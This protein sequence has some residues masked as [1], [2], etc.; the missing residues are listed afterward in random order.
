MRLLT[1]SPLLDQI[2]DALLLGKIVVV[3]L[4]EHLLPQLLGVVPVSYDISVVGILYLD[5]P[6]IQKAPDF[7]ELARISAINPFGLD[8]NPIPHHQ[9]ILIKQL[10]PSIIILRP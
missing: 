5:N 3:T 10:I 6:L 1:G 9:P 8:Q 7:L 2:S 4:V